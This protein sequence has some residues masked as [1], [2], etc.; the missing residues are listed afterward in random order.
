M[1]SANSAVVRMLESNLT[2]ADCIHPSGS[3]NEEKVVEQSGEA[4]RVGSVKMVAMRRR[5]ED[6]T[7]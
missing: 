2:K 7:H 1:L 3:S 6:I 4:V 5:D